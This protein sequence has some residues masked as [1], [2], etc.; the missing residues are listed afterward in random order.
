MTVV[1]PSETH[2]TRAPSDAT[3]RGNELEL[4]SY[5]GG[6]GN[7]PFVTFTKSGGVAG[8]AWSFVSVSESLADDVARNLLVNVLLPSV[9]LLMFLV[10]FIW[11]SGKTVKRDERTAKWLAAIVTAFGVLMLQF[12]VVQM[13]NWAN[14]ATQMVITG[15]AYT[16]LALLTFADVRPTLPRVAGGVLLAWET[17]IA[18]MFVSA[19]AVDSY[20]V[21][22]LLAVNYYDVNKLIFATFSTLFL[23][24]MAVVGYA[25]SDPRYRRIAIA[26]PPTV[27]AVSLAM[28]RP[29]TYVGTS[30]DFVY[31]LFFV[32]VIL[33]AV[34]LFG[35]PAFLLGRMIPA[36][37]S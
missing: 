29:V 5:E 19:I 2:I 1:R 33:V 18:V 21:P 16:V 13:A 15:G 35:I 10:G 22:R 37:K 27:L 3:V 7:G 6:R 26:L 12:G 32:V 28:A 34:T 30:L 8:E 24:S 36:K 4:T 31:S 14:H 23:L 17:G 25:V 11:V 9:S 20:V